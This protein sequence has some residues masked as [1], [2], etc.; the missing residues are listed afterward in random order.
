MSIWSIGALV[1]VV[2]RTVIAGVLLVLAMRR[3]TPGIFAAQAISDAAVALLVTAYALHPLRAALGWVSV[4]LFLY[5]IAWEGLAAAQRLSAIGEIADAPLSDA[6]L[7][8]GMSHWVWD[9][10]GLAPAFIMGVLVAGA[11]VLPGEWTLPGEPSALSC[12]PAEVVSG[13]DL[14]LGMKTPH[15]ADLG[16]FTPHRGYLTL[17]S[18]PAA[19][20]VPVAER[21][22]YRDRLVLP[23]ASASGRR[24]RA[25]EDEA[26]FVDSG[27][28]TFTM[29]KYLD[30]SVSFMCVVRYRP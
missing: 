24:R 20:T 19:G 8:G 26:V 30:A 14:L 23:T 2:A 4:P 11:I 12:S 3:R 25:T 28:Y 17:R 22:E 10:G 6:E 21:F 15:G 7:F 9:L 16:V 13:G 29:S 1:Y 18:A 27:T 5:F